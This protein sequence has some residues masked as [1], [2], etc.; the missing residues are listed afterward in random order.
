MPDA[1]VGQIVGLVLTAGGAAFVTALIA[2]L[3]DLR[4]GVA[5]GRRE[6]VRDLMAWRDDLDEARKVAQADA[7][8]WR[9]LAGERGGQLRDHGHVPAN[10]YPVPPSQSPA[11]REAAAQAAAR[12]RYWRRND[13]RRKE[14]QR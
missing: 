8:F 9:D 3:K 10:P 2:G 12:R 6:V 7:D 5:A 1:T 14:Q 4:G 13:D 11:V